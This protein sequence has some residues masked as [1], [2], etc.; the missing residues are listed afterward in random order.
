V[1]PA[2]RVRATAV[3]RPAPPRVSIVVPCYNYGHFLPDCVASLLRQQDVEVEVIV[4]DD[5]SPDGSVAVA[6]ALAAA[7]PRVRV[8]AHERNRGHIAT[9][10]HGLEHV[11]GEFVVLL[12]ADD[13]LTPGALSR[14]TALMLARPSVGLVYGHPVVFDTAQPP[15]TGRTRPR[16]WSVW[17][18]EDWIRA[19]CRRSLSIIYSPEAVVRTDVQRAVGGYDPALPHTGD[20]AMWLRIAAISD[21]GRVNGTDQA[22]RREHPASMMTT[23]YSGALVDLRGRQAAYQDFFTGP[24]AGLRDGAGL[25]AT[26][27]R[28]LAQQA[29]DEA[30]RGLGSGAGED[31]VAPF[32]A[33]ANE[34]H[35]AAA[36]LWQ[37][38]DLQVRRRI[39][40]S[41]GGTPPIPV[42]TRL[43]R[44]VFDA[45][46]DLEG[47]LRWQ[48]WHRSGT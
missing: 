21:V 31:Q 7:D 27:R 40:G 15:P 30:C 8:L 41:P 13:L 33:F 44:T 17:R 32:V 46:R 22:Y 39:A 23:T 25:W 14:A 36:S 28:R 12:S 18:G 47:R 4:V 16:T 24:G 37:W 2:V 3:S 45:R 34:L 43:R 11:T 20:L 48:R 1:T 19:Q 38:R 9:Y 35:P 10:N 26:A 29:L 6:D 42:A 5:A